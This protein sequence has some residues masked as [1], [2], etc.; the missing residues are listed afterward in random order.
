MLRDRKKAWAKMSR[1]LCRRYMTSVFSVSLTNLEARKSSKK[2]L[3]DGC[4]L[5]QS[6]GVYKNL[7]LRNI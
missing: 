2:D 6:C 4:G 7:S 1:E 5:L 3:T